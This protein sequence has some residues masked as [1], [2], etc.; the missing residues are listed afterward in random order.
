MVGY[1]KVPIVTPLPLRPQQPPLAFQPT[2]DNPLHPQP[3]RVTLPVAVEAEL[4]GERQ[5]TLP[6]APWLSK[7]SYPH[8]FEVSPAESPSS[9]LHPVALHAVNENHSSSSQLHHLSPR[10][11]QLLISCTPPLIPSRSPS[12]SSSR[13]PSHFSA[14][15]RSPALASKKPKASVKQATRA[16]LF[17]RSRKIAC[18]RPQLDIPTDQRCG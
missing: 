14:A 4:L 17:C 8:T 5:G 2:L 6:A 10:A 16:C 11:K 7:S 9:M 15:L 3:L 18:G 13:S 1:S 12:R